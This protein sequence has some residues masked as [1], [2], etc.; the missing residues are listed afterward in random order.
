MSDC[1]VALGY[2]IGLDYTNPHINT[3]QVGAVY[4]VRQDAWGVRQDVYGAFWTATVRG[5]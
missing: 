2:V 5:F 1:R 4:G 3:F